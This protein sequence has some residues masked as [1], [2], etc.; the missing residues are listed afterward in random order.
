MISTGEKEEP[1]QEP[2][3]FNQQSDSDLIQLDDVEIFDIA[4]LLPPANPKHKFYLFLDLDETLIHSHV[5]YK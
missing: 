3:D 4:P 1:N 2:L 5:Q